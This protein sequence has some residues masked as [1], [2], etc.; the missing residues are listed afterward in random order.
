MSGRYLFVPPPP[1]YPHFCAPPTDG[2][3]IW[4]SI[5]DDSPPGWHPAP[6]GTV[7]QCDVC[8]KVWVVRRPR[9]AQD[10][11]YWGP[12]TRRERRRRERVSSYISEPGSAVVIRNY[13]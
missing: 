7:W 1:V 6:V 12:E 3:M 13:W 2:D 10:G 11:D 8:S 5:A 9:P 4:P